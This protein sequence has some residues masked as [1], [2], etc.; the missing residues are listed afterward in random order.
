[1]YGAF[2]RSGGV[3]DRRALAS[4]RAEA[5][6]WLTRD[7]AFEAMSLEHGTVAWREWPQ[8]DRA[9][10]YLDE[11][12][13]QLR[14]GGLLARWGAVLDRYAFEQWLAHRQH[15]ALGD[16]LREQELSLFGDLQVGVSERDAWAIQPILLTGYLLGAPP[17]RTNPDGQPWGYGVYD[18]QQ[19]LEADGGAGPVLRF[20][21]ARMDKMLAEYDGLRIDHPHGLVCP[22]VY[23]TDEEPFRAVQGGAR[24]FASPDLDDHPWLASWAIARPDQLD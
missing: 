6:E 16:V 4:F 10:P 14:T 11:P 2:L 7:A 24:L 21:G 20:L 9:F 22:W 3:P 18:P 5:G 8:A 12:A 19:V 23:R 15:A 17:S 13:R 1:A